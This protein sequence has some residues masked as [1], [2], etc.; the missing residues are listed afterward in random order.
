MLQCEPLSSRD[1][2]LDFDPDTRMDSQHLI[3]CR[4]LASVALALLATACIPACGSSTETLN[5]VRIEHAVASSILS[6]RGLHATVA[7]PSDVPEKA[8]RV[9]TC[10]ARL[11]VG[12]YPVTVTETNGS[13][14]VRY[15]NRRP[16]V[17]LN[18]AQVEH[19]IAASIAHQRGL[20]ATVSCPAEV[21]QRAGIVFRCTALVRGR[22]YPFV[23]SET[24]DKGHVRYLGQ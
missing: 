8:G 7:C 10:T 15:E 18:I 3:G 24:D 17:A 23:V 14:H 12:S 9:F 4:R 2:L 5:T 13:G 20:A 22:R 19:A 21:L 6:E 1:P 11:D 16:L